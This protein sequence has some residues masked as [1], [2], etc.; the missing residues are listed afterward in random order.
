VPGRGPAQSARQGVATAGGGLEI[1]TLGMI[2][3]LKDGE[4][5]A[6]RLLRPPAPAFAWLHPPALA[7]LKPNQGV[8]RA[9]LGDEWFRGYDHTQQRR[10]VSHRLNEMNDRRLSAPLT[11]MLRLDGEYVH[12]DLGGCHYDVHRLFELSEEAKDTGDLLLSPL[13]GDVEE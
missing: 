4:D 6:R 1:R 9:V 7:T 2:R 12:V 5:F 8:T 11:G 10:K 13:L 3:I